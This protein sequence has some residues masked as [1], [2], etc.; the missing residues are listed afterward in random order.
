MT[1]LHPPPEPKKEPSPL[2]SEEID[3]LR[4]VTAPARRPPRGDRPKCGAKT[5]LGRPCVARAVW[6]PGAPEPRNGRCRNHGGLSTGP[7]TPEGQQRSAEALRKARERKRL[8]AEERK[9]FEADEEQKRIATKV[10]HDAGPGEAVPPQ[11]PPRQPAP[12]PLSM[13]QRQLMREEFE[14]RL[15]LPVPAEP[16]SDPWRVLR[17]RR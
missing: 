9:R 17:G 8:E 11:Q 2:T 5:R 6:L 4:N 10:S 14:S 7:K 13:R 1:P 16:T 3:A 15:A 12:Q